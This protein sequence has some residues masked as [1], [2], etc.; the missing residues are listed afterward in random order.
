MLTGLNF[1]VCF[2]CYLHQF[3]QDFWFYILLLLRSNLKKRQRYSLKSFYVRYTNRFI[4]SICKQASL[5]F[6]SRFDAM[7]VLKYEKFSSTKHYVL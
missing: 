7:R 6:R 3:N 4:V 5:L 2:S 1:L